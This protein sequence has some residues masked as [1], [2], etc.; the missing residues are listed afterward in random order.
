MP[1]SY[2][3]KIPLYEC[4]LATIES[5]CPPIQIKGGVGKPIIETDE[6][7]RRKYKMPET[8]HYI[9][10]ELAIE[11]IRRN[12]LLGEGYSDTERENDVI[13]LLSSLPSIELEDD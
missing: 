12:G 9:K 7:I 11:E 1:W 6:T 4:K 8:F 3:M 5:S 2:N 10:L 13:N